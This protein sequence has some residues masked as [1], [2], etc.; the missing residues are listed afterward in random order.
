MVHEGLDGVFG[1]VVSV[2][3][4]RGEFNGAPVTADG[5]FELVRCLVVK[6]VPDY[7][8]DLGLMPALIY[9]LVGFDEI[10]SF[11]CFHALV[12]DVI[13]I[14]FN[15]HH[16]VFVS[17]LKDDKKAT[18]LISVHSLFCGIIDADVYILVFEARHWCERW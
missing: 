2:N 11:V 8:N 10:I 12:I 13:A 17:P 6:D 4:R 18:S 9:G 7:V 14:K 5:G 3:D 1:I 15:G 16:D